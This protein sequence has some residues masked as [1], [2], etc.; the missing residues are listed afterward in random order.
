MVAT[1]GAE[2]GA[3][4]TV[5]LAL[6][7]PAGTVTLDGTPATGLLLDSTTCAPPTGVALF[8]TTVPM[9]GIPPLTLVGLTV[10]EERER[11]E[12]GAGT[13]VPGSTNVPASPV[14]KRNAQKEKK[15]S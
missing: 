12:T 4:L 5:K 11:K 14:T 13:R 2:T 3:V 7:E 10:R 8:S 6:L 9:E 15:R 1:V